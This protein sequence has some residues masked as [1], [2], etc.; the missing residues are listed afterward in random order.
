MV[1][2]RIG[3]I[4]LVPDQARLELTKK[5]FSL[6]TKKFLANFAAQEEVEQIVADEYQAQFE[7]K[8][9]RFGER[10]VGAISRRNLSL[11][12]TGA[13]RSSF[14]VSAP[15]WMATRVGSENNFTLRIRNSFKQIGPRT[16]LIDKPLVSFFEDWKTGLR[17]TGLKF[18]GIS[19]IGARRI[20][21]VW[22]KS[23]SSIL[24]EVGFQ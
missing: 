24:R 11:V 3:F 12:E 4:T 15:S 22:L 9:A 8:G 19:E 14:S 6:L 21:Q 1:K 5:R 23:F 2:R 16:K 7:S 10:W 13:F 18:G 20:T 17:I